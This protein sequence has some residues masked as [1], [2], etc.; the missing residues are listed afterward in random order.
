MSIPTLSK[1]ASLV[2]ALLA[3]LFGQ[4]ALSADIV[5]RNKIVP[6]KSVVSLGDIADIQATSVAERQRLALTPLWVA[7]PV[8]EQRFVTSQQVLDIL[9]NRGFAP[10]E[11]NLY[12]APRVAIGWQKPDD[13]EAA[14]NESVGDGGA[15]MPATNSM[16]FRVPPKT[17]FAV[18]QEQLKRNPVFLSN[19]QQKHLAD[20]VREAVVAYVE[21]RTSKNGL[22]EVDVQLP[23]RHGELLSLQTG[24]LTI[25]GGRTPWTGRQQLTLKFDSEK[26]PLELAITA[27]IYDT[28]PVLVAKRPIARN[29]LL[30]AADVAIEKPPRNARVPAGRVR[31]TSLDDALGKEASR[32]IR[33]GEVVTADLCLAPRMIDRNA[34]VSIVSAGG[35]IVVRRYGKALSDARYGDVAEVQLLDS[36]QRLMGRVVGQGEL[37]TLGTSLPPRTASGLRQTPIYR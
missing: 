31:V 37:A 24:E 15:P 5:L 21:N 23:R 20:Q 14:P 36:R 28:T 10:S 32:A 25:D 7:P 29:Q 35:G 4:V 13:V 3:L 6:V 9:V 34:I 33:E 2:A 19:L 18:P 26:G 30:T 27:T 16:G 12:G 8:G 17:S 11:L 1:L 22:I